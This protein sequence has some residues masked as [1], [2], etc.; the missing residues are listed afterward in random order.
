MQLVRDQLVGETAGEGHE[1]VG[2]DG[3]GDCDAHGVDAPAEDGEGQSKLPG[4][5]PWAVPPKLP[6]S[7]SF[8]A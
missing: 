7:R 1:V 6:L 4:K 2:G 5:R 3:A 8:F